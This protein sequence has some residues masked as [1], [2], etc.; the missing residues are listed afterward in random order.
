MK[1]ILSMLMLLPLLG[2]SACDIGLQT[3][4]SSEYGVVFS[5]LP[6][7]LGGGV[8]EK[9]AVP[10]ETEFIM[11]WET[12]YRI[13]TSIRSIAWGNSQS[14]NVQEQ[15]YVETRALDGNE[16]G[17]AMTVRYRVKPEYVS[18][19]IQN[20]GATNKEID[21]LVRVA[22]RADI[23]TFMN[24]LRTL[25]FFDATLRDQ[26]ISSLRDALN[27]RLSREGIEI[28]E[29]IYV[30]HRF[31]KAYQTLIDQT[32]AKREEMQQ[33]KKKIATVIEQKK[34]EFNEAQ[35]RV[36]RTVAE[37]DG[38]K[39]QAELRGDAYLQAKKNESEQ[40]LATGMA[41]VEGMMKKV[42]ALSG[43]GGEAILRLELVREII[44]RN[45]KFVV[46]NSA[47][48]EGGVNLGVNRLDTNQLLD[49]TGFMTGIAEAVREP[50]PRPA[51]ELKKKSTPRAETQ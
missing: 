32:Q 19:I 44:K 10:G 50:S 48:S 45:P 42:E 34:Q 27:R 28:D 36:N 2:L 30:D 47:D 39:R 8:K 16:V 12:F 18:Y 4:E 46:I 29:V 9:T 22:S 3:L 38:Y 20:V 24:E 37:A 25:N 7:A 26:A 14:Q 49:Q 11:P 1:R 51:L 6:P 15:E 35:A 17:L 5:A 31:E 33:E 41:E 40:I 21:D 23:R 43:P 13:D